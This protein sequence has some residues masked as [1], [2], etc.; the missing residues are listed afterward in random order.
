M[1]ATLSVRNLS[2]GYAGRAVL[3]ALS[4]DL[5][6]GEFLSL[7]GPNGVG[8]TTLLRTLGGSLAPLAGSALLDGADLSSLS[9]RELASKVA[10]VAQSAR[11]DWPFTVAEAVSLGRY[12]RLGWFGRLGS[13][14]RREVEKALARTSLSELSD[15]LVTELSGGELQLVMIARALAQEPAILLLDEPV[16]SLDVKHQVQVLQLLR[17]LA[18]EGITVVASL[19]DL[20]LASL[21]ADRIALF[22]DGRLLAAGTPTEILREDLIGEAFGIPVL[23]GS[24]PGGPDIPLVYHR[25]SAAGASG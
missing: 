4:L 19:H 23:I 12:P 21:Y 14:D 20:N 9:R 2:V 17:D 8:K 13:G 24:Y 18:A 22:A 10:R 11:A 5:R 16:S 25:R 1:G 7:A 15:R 3:R 6:P